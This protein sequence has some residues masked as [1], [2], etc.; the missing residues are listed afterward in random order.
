MKTKFPLDLIY[1]LRG[2]PKN[3]GY[4]PFCEQWVRHWNSGMWDQRNA[5]AESTPWEDFDSLLRSDDR[6]KA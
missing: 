1:S 6:E 5:P 4:L 2:D 3:L